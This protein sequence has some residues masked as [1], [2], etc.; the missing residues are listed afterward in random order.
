MM[1]PIGNSASRAA[2]MPGADGR[3]FPTPKAVYRARER[4]SHM[5]AVIVRL[6]AA[7]GT[8]TVE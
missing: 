2:R 1:V 7:Q 4:Q 3:G 8:S 6:A 5:L